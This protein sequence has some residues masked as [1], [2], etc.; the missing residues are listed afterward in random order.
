ML[1]ITG[2]G[3]A[4]CPAGPDVTLSQERCKDTG[5]A[6][7]AKGAAARQRVRWYQGIDR[8]VRAASALHVTCPALVT[9]QA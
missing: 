8:R 6:V 5:E 4:P 3:L 1:S 7:S 9:A 2:T